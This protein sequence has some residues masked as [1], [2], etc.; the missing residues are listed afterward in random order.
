MHRK[1]FKN[2]MEQLNINKILEAYK[3]DRKKLAAAL[4]PNNRYPDEAFNRIVTGVAKLDSDQIA[5]LA[6]YL[7]VFVHTLYSVE[8]SGWHGKMGANGIV[9][10]KGDYSAS[11]NN[12]SMS[13][14][15]CNKHV[16]SLVLKSEPTSLREILD[17]LDSYINNQNH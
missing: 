2:E 16:I 9:L 4:F 8:D 3:P 14:Y 7:G 10:S 15:C 13:L 11:I 1:K 17:V 12:G 6:N 5:I